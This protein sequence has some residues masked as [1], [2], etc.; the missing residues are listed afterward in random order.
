M[1]SILCQTASTMDATISEQAKA[2][3]K[4]AT[5]EDLDN[6]AVPYLATTDDLLASLDK[7]NKNFKGFREKRSKIFSVLTAVCR[8]IELISTIGSSLSA[9][10]PPAASLGALKILLTAADGV[11]ASYDAILD[12][13][14]TLKVRRLVLSHD[15]KSARQQAEVIVIINELMKRSFKIGLPRA[16][17][18]IHSRKA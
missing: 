14:S 12:L 8:P 2:Q 10:F 16:V 3:Y 1:S 5:G 7:E 11:S 4:L 6:P 9:V 15:I 18:D 17:E 13:L